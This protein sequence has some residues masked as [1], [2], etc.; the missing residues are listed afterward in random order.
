MV[1]GKGSEQFHDLRPEVL[2]AMIHWLEEQQ[3]NLTDQ[4]HL[5]PALAT[6]YPAVL[7]MYS[8]VL[9]TAVLTNCCLL[10]YT[11]RHRLYLYL[12]LG[13]G[14]LLLHCPVLP[15]TVVVLV[16]NDWLL[17]RTACHLL[18]LIQDMS[19]HFTVL[20][21]LTLAIHLLR[22]V[23]SQSATQKCCDV[24]RHVHT[25]H[26]AEPPDTSNTFT[27]RCPQPVC[28]PEVLPCYRICPH[29]SLC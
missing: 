22:D 1:R 2:G 26:C 11:Y 13:L 10:I 14:N 25:L 16:F 20:S 8:L 23:H 3:G 9:I 24:T 5:R 19:T 27:E 12:N 17:G 21:H 4:P 6:L 15:L 18:P 7:A 28:Y 29:T